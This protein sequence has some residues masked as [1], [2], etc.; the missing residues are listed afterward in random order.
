M[1][2]LVNDNE[3][4]IFVQIN[5]LLKI[6]VQRPLFTKFHLNVQSKNRNKFRSIVLTMVIFIVFIVLYCW[7]YL[8]M[9][10]RIDLNL[11]FIGIS[12]TISTLILESE[13]TICLWWY[14]WN[15]KTFLGTLFLFEVQLGTRMELRII[16]FNLLKGLKMHF[17]EIY[18]LI[19]IGNFQPTCIKSNNVWM[20][21][22]A[23]YADLS[24]WLIQDYINFIFS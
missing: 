18:W 8:A 4:K 2:Q 9:R 6:S 24:Y 20:A 23:D 21:V 22:L 17:I 5:S 19:K 1:K 12:K 10:R 3:S 7:Y 14:I 13:P 11:I 15:L 16:V